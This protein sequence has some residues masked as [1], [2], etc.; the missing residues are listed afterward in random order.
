MIDDLISKFDVNK[1]VRYYTCCA[2]IGTVNYWGQSSVTVSHGI[3]VRTLI[4]FEAFKSGR[5]LEHGRL[6]RD[7]R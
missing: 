2:N 3:S 6:L 1:K 7:L 5:L 4:Y